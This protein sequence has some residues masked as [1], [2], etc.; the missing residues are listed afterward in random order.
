MA[1]QAIR[2]TTKKE[3]LFSCPLQ[4]LP[5]SLIQPIIAAAGR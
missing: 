1:T 3:Q 5:L 2:E 4:S